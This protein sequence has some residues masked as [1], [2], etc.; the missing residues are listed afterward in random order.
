MTL[1]RPDYDGRPTMMVT[2][3]S[4]RNDGRPNDADVLGHPRCWSSSRL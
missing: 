1:F 4:S 2:F 3:V